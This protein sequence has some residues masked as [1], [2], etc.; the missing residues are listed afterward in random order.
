MARPQRQRIS[1]ASAT[2]RHVVVPG[3]TITAMHTSS[4]FI[5]ELVTLFASR[6]ILPERLLPWL[7][8]ASGLI[9]VVIG[10]RMFLSRLRQK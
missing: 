6:F 1:S 7:G 10:L 9:V 2:P 3:L 8:L 4:V 5:L